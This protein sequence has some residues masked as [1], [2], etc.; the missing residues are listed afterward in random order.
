MFSIGRF[1]IITQVSIKSLRK[2]HELEILIP[3]YVDDENGYRYYR[4]ESIEKAKVI[5]SLKSMGFTYHE[6]KSIMEN[7]SND[8]DIIVFLEKK[9][10]SILNKIEEYKNIQ[11]DIDHVINN[12]RRCKMNSQQYS[13]EIIEKNVEDIIFAGFRMKG[14]YSEI[15]EAFR[16]VGKKAGRYIS[17]KPLAIYYDGEYKE[18]DA[19]FEGGFPLSKSIESDQI[20]CRVLKGGRAL[21]LVHKGQYQNLGQSYS[22]L[23]NYV[24]EKNYKINE[25]SREVYHKGPGM[26]FKGNPEKYLTEIQL[27]IIE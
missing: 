12:A 24:D 9:R 13:S 15:G 17:G 21:T 5:V 8:E 2:F 26:I 7:Y 16:K 11:S 1:S 22:R 18:Q 27:F 23:F 19:N 4:E 10:N 3:D 14:V 25:V 6:I 20:D